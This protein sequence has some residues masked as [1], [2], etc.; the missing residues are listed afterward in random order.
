VPLGKDTIQVTII[1]NSRQRQEEC[2]A[3]CG[4][5]WSSPE[6]VALASQRIKDRFGDEIQLAYI[7]LSKAVANHDALEWNE[8][9]KNKNLSVPLLLLNG[10]LRISGRF[11]IRQLL[12]TVEVE[13]E[14]RAPDE[15]ASQL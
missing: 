10:Q 11:D 2:E 6:A 4:I 14:I 13:I 7:D 5:D 12:D 8:V 15:R 1:D 3:E 9:I